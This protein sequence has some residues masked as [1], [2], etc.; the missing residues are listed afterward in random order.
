MIRILFVC[1]GNICR[2]PMGEYLLRDIAARKG[3]TEKDIYIESAATSTEEIGNG[4]Y[5]PVKKL[6]EERGIN[7]SKKRARRLRSDEYWNWDYI[8]CF[9]AENVS[10]IGRI[11]GQDLGHKVHLL[12]SYAGQQGDIADPWYTRDFKLCMEQTENGCK[13]F[14]ELLTRYRD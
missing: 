10:E 13:A 2:S 12:G 5:P 8:L 3:W 11:C 7:C 14:L 1:H 6:L 9:D 4:V